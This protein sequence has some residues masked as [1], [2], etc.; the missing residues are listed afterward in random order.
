MNAVAR[1]ELERD[2]AAPGLIGMAERGLVPDAALRLGIRRLCAQRLREEGAGDL[3]QADAR[4]RELLE[5]LRRSPIAIETD[6]A[7]E[8]HYEVP[9]RFFELCLGRRLKYSSAFYRTGNESLDEAEDAML[10]LYTERAQLADGQSILELGCGWGS[11]ALYN[12]KKFPRSQIT[13]I[14]NSRTQKEHIDA[15]A[16]KRGRQLGDNGKRLA[17]ARKQQKR[18]FVEAN[19]PA[20]RA[21]WDQAPSASEAARRL[22]DAKLETPKGTKWYPATVL[23][24]AAVAGLI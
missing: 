11:L 7:N 17:E 3:A 9:A 8:Q 15:E 16:K 2:S 12:A 14:S 21:I 20:F 22:N 6:A 4:F 1:P 24:F 13:A 18:E 23:S 19:L 10:A 5:E